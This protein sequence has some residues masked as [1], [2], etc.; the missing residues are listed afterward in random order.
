MPNP[1][2][3]TKQRPAQ[4]V[5]RPPSSDR[6]REALRWSCSGY[7]RENTGGRRDSATVVVQDEKFAESLWARIKDHVK[8]VLEDGRRVLGIPDKFLVSRYQPNQYFAPH[9]DGNMKVSLAA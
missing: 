4:G 1:P 8:P 7:Q 2:P 5:C 3:P 9:F 6:G